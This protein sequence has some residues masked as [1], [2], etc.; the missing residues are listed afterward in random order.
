MLKL[1][2]RIRENYKLFNER[3]EEYNMFENIKKG[4]GLAMGVMIAGTFVQVVRELFGGKP[5][6]NNENPEEE[7]V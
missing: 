5:Q 6:E 2:L 3:K 1:K 4:F 7:E